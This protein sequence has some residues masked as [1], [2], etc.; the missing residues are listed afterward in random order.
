M[1]T[2]TCKDCDA[3]VFYLFRQMHCTLIHFIY[4]RYDIQ[5]CILLFF[6]FAVYQTALLY[7]GTH[8]LIIW[9]GGGSVYILY[10]CIYLHNVYL[11][12]KKT[13]FIIRNKKKKIW[14]DH[15]RSVGFVCYSN[16]IKYLGIIFGMRIVASEKFHIESA[17]S[18][19][20]M[21][22]WGF[23]CLAYRPYIWAVVGSTYT[24]T[25]SRKP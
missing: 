21:A 15:R 10:I 8:A 19:F 20:F 14:N 22:R 25:K 16:D 7:I 5:F 24:S 11:F 23:G 3:A 2:N 12:K 9:R 1:H 4:S 6:L 13:T 18:N 17:T